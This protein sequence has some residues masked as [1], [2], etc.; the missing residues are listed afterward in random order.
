MTVWLTELLDSERQYKNSCKAS[1]VM[2]IVTKPSIAVCLT[3]LYT[4]VVFKDPFYVLLVFIC[5]CSVF[6][7]FW[8][9]HHYLSSD[10]L[11]RLL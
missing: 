1:T 6:K 7:L 8:L 2:N 10:W 3:M 9:S 4:I 5:M 11:E